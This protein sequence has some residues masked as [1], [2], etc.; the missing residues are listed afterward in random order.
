MDVLDRRVPHYL[1]IYRD[2]RQRIDTGEWE[3]GTRLPAQRDLSSQFGVAVMT[4]RH[5]L[6]LLE[7][8][9]LVQFRHGKGT[10][11]APRPLSYDMSRLR[12]LAQEMAAQGHAL[13]TRVLSS[14]FSRAQPRV[15]ELLALNGSEEVYVLERL[16]IVDGRP[17]VYQR[18]HLPARHGRSIG[19]ADLTTRSLYDFLTEALDLEVTHALE[20]LRPVTLSASIA[21]LF[22]E[23]KGTPAILSE[24]LTFTTG[25]EPLIFDE[26]YMPGDR[27]VISADRYTNDLTMRYSVFGEEAGANHSARRHGKSRLSSKTEA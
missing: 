24:R 21:K 7:R 8:E 10:Y 13:V 1:R 15:A 2:L 6:Q 4:I 18:S 12:S 22:A 9:G 11:V 27:V 19:G 16:R 26:A 25:D 17:A 14:S 23:P 20:T 5:A 3:A